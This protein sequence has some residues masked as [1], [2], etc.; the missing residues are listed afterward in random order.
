MA[1]SKRIYHYRLPDGRALEVWSDADLGLRG[2]QVRIAP[3]TYMATH[4]RR[5]RDGGTTRVVCEIGE[6]YVPA[7]R[8]KQ[9]TT[10]NRTI[11]ERIVDPARPT[12]PQ[13]LSDEDLVAEFLRIYRVPSWEKGFPLDGRTRTQLEAA[14][15]AALES[16]QQ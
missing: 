2:W 6:L 9:P 14:L 1:D 16:G 15:A 10:W 4:V 11:I 7:A 13:Q 8:L 12:P 3:D 5:F